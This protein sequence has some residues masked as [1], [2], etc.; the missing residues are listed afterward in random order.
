MFKYLRYRWWMWR[1]ARHFRKLQAQQDFDSTLTIERYYDEHEMSRS[2]R[3]GVLTVDREY[4]CFQIPQSLADDYPSYDWLKLNAC[5]VFQAL[6][7]LR[8]HRG[9]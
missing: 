9:V 8:R 1:L 3:F 5:L 2:T 4:S 6:N 7:E